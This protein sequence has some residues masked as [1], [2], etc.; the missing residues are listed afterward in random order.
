MN[1]T[2]ISRCIGV[3]AFSLLSCVSSYERNS[4]A[5][6]GKGSI[7]DDAGLDSKDANLFESSS[8]TG[9]DDTRTNRTPT[10]IDSSTPETDTRDLD[11]TGSATVVRETE[12]GIGETD[13]SNVEDAVS[14]SPLRKSITGHITLRGLGLE[15]V[16]VTAENINN[17]VLG[18]TIIN[19]NG[20]YFLARTGPGYL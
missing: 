12:S 19:E 1:R 7:V 20:D 2:S 17:E 18:E 4:E 9:E 11:D 3:L 5:G 16:R 14:N 15:G 6:S 13:A 10:E 8:D